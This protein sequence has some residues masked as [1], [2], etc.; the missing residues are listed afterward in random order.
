MKIL[1]TGANG[2]I[3]SNVV[4]Q[5]LDGGHEVV[6]CDIASNNIDAR[7]EVKQFD[8]FSIKESDNAFTTLGSPDV[9]L[10]LAWR[11]GFVHNSPKQMLDLSSHYKFLTNLINNGLKHLAVMGTMHEVG[12]H[13]G[14]IDSDTPCNPQSLYGI[15]KNTLRQSIMLFAAQNGCKLQWIRAFYIYGDDL[16]NH[17]IFT[18]LIEASEAGKKT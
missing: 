16:K 17:S 8:I 9:C 14:K 10:H 5:L 11:D 4:K 7:A 18:K 12:Y 3:G 15:A 2:Y 6:A 13:E 1:V